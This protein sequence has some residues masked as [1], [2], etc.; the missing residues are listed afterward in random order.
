MS[1]SDGQKVNA[2]I[3]NAAFMSRNSDTGTTGQVDLN[4]VDAASGS[5]VANAQRELNGL[6]SYTG[7]SS[8]RD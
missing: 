8:D 4:N 2:A 1:V 7:S 3:T 5:S 6:N